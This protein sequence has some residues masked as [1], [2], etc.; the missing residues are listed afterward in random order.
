MKIAKIPC[1]CC[2][3]GLTLA[4]QNDAGI[5]LTLCMCG[6]HKRNTVLVQLREDHGWD[7]ASSLFQKRPKTTTNRRLLAGKFKS[8][9]ALN[10]SLR[11]LARMLGIGEAE[12]SQI[13]AEEGGE[14]AYVRLQANLGG[15]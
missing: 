2:N 14:E 12:L 11:H 6:G 13:V 7:V 8:M 15:L 5:H 4:L 3:A 1:P 9:E 10:K